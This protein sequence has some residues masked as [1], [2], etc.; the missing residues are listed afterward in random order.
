MEVTAG[1]EHGPVLAGRERGGGWREERDSKNAPHCASYSFFADFRLV[2]KMHGGVLVR[3]ACVCGLK[4][5]VFFCLQFLCCRCLV[6]GGGRDRNGAAW[7]GAGFWLYPL[8][9]Y[10]PERGRPD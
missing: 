2:P 7:D 4:C 1:G 10:V 3:P 5:A 8:L 6:E 9:L